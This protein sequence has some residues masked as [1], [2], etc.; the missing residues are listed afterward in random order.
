MKGIN[1]FDLDLLNNNSLH[2]KIQRKM[3][4]ELLFNKSKSNLFIP[5]ISGQHF[6]NYL[7]LLVER[8]YTIKL[9]LNKR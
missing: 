3:C 2:K 5:F 4:K 9:E 7:F 6:T 8:N 1:K